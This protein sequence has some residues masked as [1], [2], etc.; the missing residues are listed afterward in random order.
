MWT[1]SLISALLGTVLPGPG[2]IYL[3][4]DIKFKKPARIGDTVFVTLVVR[5]KR[6][7]K[8]IVTFDC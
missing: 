1:G 5:D 4:Q 2:T 6:A 8:P 7:D 3:E